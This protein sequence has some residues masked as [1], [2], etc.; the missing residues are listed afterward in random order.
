MIAEY[1]LATA[2]LSLALAV[3]AGPSLIAAYRWRYRG[4]KLLNDR[5]GPPARKR[6]T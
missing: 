2:V 4:G 5:L 1:L 3:L 6:R